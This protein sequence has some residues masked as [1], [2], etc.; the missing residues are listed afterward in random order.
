MLKRFIFALLP[1]FFLFGGSEFA[2]R[3]VGW[4]K[5][6][7]AF[8]HNTPFWVTDPDL[9][10]KKFPHKEENRSFNVSTNL[11]GLRLTSQTPAQREKS[12]HRI[13]TLGCSTTFGWGVD[14]PE[15]YP[16]VLQKYVK[17][18]KYSTEIVN[19][20][21][22]GYTSFQGSILWDKVLKNYT[23]DVVLIGYIVQDA[24]K[25]AYSDRSQA[26]LQQDHAFLKSNVLYRS[27]IY[28]A[29]R[30][31]LGDVQIQAKERRQGDDSTGVFRVPPEDYVDNLRSLISRIKEKRGVPVLFGYPLERTGY[32]EY[33]RKILMAAAE[34]LNVAL[35]DPQKKMEEASRKEQLYFTNDRG[36]ANAKGNEMIAKWVYAF[37]E[38]ENLLK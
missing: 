27:K 38:Q 31:F 7:S 32:T 4:P 33:H 28:L 30:S 35:F 16:A 25:A 13:M 23:P 37:L 14:N 15:S 26:I 10:K 11:D 36:H 34:E 17:E 12:S 9:I 22:P 5:I 19:G 24:R 18:A 20:G 6:T 3:V 21:Q 2:L 8:E 29:L 1:F